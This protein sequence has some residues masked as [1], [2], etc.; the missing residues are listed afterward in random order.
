M[1]IQTMFYRSIYHAMQIF[2]IKYGL[3]RYIK[4]I[5]LLIPTEVIIVGW[6]THHL[7]F[8]YSYSVL[9]KYFIMNMHHF[10]NEER[11]FKINNK[12]QSEKQTCSR[13]L[14]SLICHHRISRSLISLIYHS[15]MYRL[16]IL[17]L[18]QLGDLE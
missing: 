5:H 6:I 18:V 8:S 2:W 3:Y 9:H 10:H 4:I 11:Y 16:A 14:I 17:C 1:P 7:H 15:F 12:T 13:S